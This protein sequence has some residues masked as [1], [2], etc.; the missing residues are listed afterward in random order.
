MSRLAGALLAA[1]LAGVQEAKTPEK[2]DLLQGLDFKKDAVLGKWAFEEKVL[3]APTVRFGRLQLPYRPPEEYDVRLVAERKAGADSIVLGLVGKGR[4]FAVVIDAFA[5]DP[6]SGVDRVDGKA[7]PDNE[8]K[9]PGRVVENGK[10]V[11]IRVSVRKDRLTVTLVGKPLVDWKA[12][13]SRVSLFEDWAV[14]DT[15]A[16]F[17]G[18]WTAPWHVHAL[19]LTPI[20]GEG[21]RTR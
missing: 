14:P 6:S 13:W 8:T 16:L 4:Q 12:D 15:G 21:R 18:A 11:E 2:V 5:K 9:H 10:K 7:F 17:L 1:I 20:T 3:V 19:E